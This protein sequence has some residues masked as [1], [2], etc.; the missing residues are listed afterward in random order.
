MRTIMTVVV[1]DGPGMTAEECE[2]MMREWVIH[3][4]HFGMMRVTQVEVWDGDTMVWQK[5]IKS[6]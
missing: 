1:D 6:S 4:D 3:H 2:R 5:F